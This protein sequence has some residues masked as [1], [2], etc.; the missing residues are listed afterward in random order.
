MSSTSPTAGT[1]DEFAGEVVRRS[2]GVPEAAAR[3]FAAAWT[4]RL[5][6]R[7]GDAGSPSTALAA[8]AAGALALVAGR[9]GGTP[10]VRAFTPDPERDGYEAAGSVLET[11][12]LDEPFLVDSVVAELTQRG[13]VVLRDVHPIIGTRRG[14]DGAL[15]EVLAPRTAPQRESVMHFELDR[16]LPAEQL[17]ALGDAVRRVLGIVD[18]V[19]ADVDLLRG[20]LAELEEVARAAAGHRDPTDAAET[21]A[22]LRWLASDRAVLL[23]AR[24]YALH[25]G[26]LEVVPG[27]GLGLLAD[28]D[29]STFA[30]GVPVS[31]LPAG[32]RE[33]VAGAQLLT[34]ARTNARSPVHRRDRMEDISV[35]RL[36]RDGEPVGISR[37]LA[38]LTTRA[39]AEPASTI[40]VLRRK[41][42]QILDAEDLVPGSH[43]HK[44]AVAAFDAFPKD[45]LLN[46]PADDLRRAIVALLGLRPGE[47]RVL[48][49]RAADDRSAS[50]IVAL[51]RAADRSTL[52]RRL[53]ALL[54]HRFGTGGIELTEVLTEDDRV[55]LHVSVHTSGT[56]PE[57]DVAELQEQ[58]RALA[59]TW[60]DLLG[61]LL[62]ERHGPELGRALAARWAPR[63]PDFYKAATS[64]RLGVE[65]VEVL[66]GMVTRGDSF[67]VGLADAR[68]ADGGPRTRV[69]LY[70]RGPKVELTQ[71]TA[72][73]EHLGLRVIE[74]VA[75]RLLADD[76][77]WVQGFIVLGDDDRPLDVGGCHARVA[78]CLAAAFRGRTE[79][80][81]LHR[82]VI[83]G[84]LDWRRIA[85]LRAY[86]RYRQRLGSRYTES[87]QNE[88]IT[89]HPVLTAKLLR[90]FE[91]RFDP[92]HDGD[93]TAEQDLREEI[94]ADLDAIELLDHDRILRNQLG[95]IDATVRT[96]IFREGRT[97][98]AFKLRSADVPAMPQPAPLW[99]IY[100]YSPTMEGIH[101]R[102]GPIARGGIRWSDRMD[103]RTEVFGLMRAQMTK[104]AVIVPTG[105]KGGFLLKGA[106][107]GGEALKDAVRREYVAYIGALLD[108]TDDRRDGRVVHPE[109]VR[110]RDEDDAYLVVAADKGTATFSDT[111][112][113]VSLRRGFWLGDAFASGGSTG[114]DHKALGITARGAWESVKRHFSELGID[115][116]A[117]PFTAVGIGD[118]SGDVFGNGMLL[119]RTIRLVAAYDHRH[120]FLDPDPDPAAGHA[121]RERLFAL[122]GRGQGSSWD[123]YD[124]ERI[125][126][127]G[128]VW[129]RTA[130][131]IPVSPEVRAALGIEDEALA[132]TDLI[133]AILRAPVDLLF[134][135]GIGTVVKASTESDADAQDR[136]SD[137]LRV[138]AADLR[139]R[140]VGEGGN[141]GF[142]H[143]ARIE[144]ARGGG[145]INADFIDNSAGV[146]CSDH[147]VNLKVLLDLAVAR[148]EL[149]PPARDAL[150]REVTEDVVGHVLYD[151][152][153]QAQIIAQE[154]RRSPGRMDALED[155]M[156][157]LE[158]R[159]ALDRAGEGLPGTDE[160]GDRRRVG[161]GLLRPE[162][163]VLVAYAKRH[164]ATALLDGPLP[165]EPFFAEDLERYFPPK[166]VASF[167]ALVPEH[168]LRRELVATIAANDLVNAL[169]PTFAS[170]GLGELGASPEAVV[171]A[172]RLA[173]AT[174]GAD[175]RWAAIEA[176]GRDVAVD[177]RWELMA[178]VD[179]LVADTARWH[180]VHDV[181]VDLAEAA[182][183]GRDGFERLGTVLPQLR[184]EAWRVA[185]DELAERLLRAGVPEDLA[186]AHT[187][188]GALVHA[189]DIVVV[190]A[191]SGRSVEEVAAVFF[192]VGERLRLEWLERAIDELPATTR[193]HRWAVQAVRDDVLGARAAL[194][195]RALREGDGDAAQVVDA[196][197][198]SRRDV[199]GRLTAFT[200]AL[201]HDG[202]AD[203]AGL[204]LAVRQLR[205]LAG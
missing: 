177:V 63:F 76:E 51:P 4:R 163:A 108:L 179:A 95:A 78:D 109:G 19:V 171:R 38:L 113:E 96:N 178:G 183:R 88:V 112:N 135:G 199:L 158:A 104:N 68:A 8:E 162:L 1:Q 39:R 121:E 17:D 132:P 129:P 149:E 169:G 47:V 97:V 146:D 136:A 191:E 180:L 150:L 141:L 36:G 75:T 188:Q 71:A 187:L 134:N 145:L 155:L 14:P 130:K 182:V 139:C 79:S 11:S 181:E 144:F 152:F 184:S 82:L 34:A 114:Y 28:D 50:I 10:A 131:S 151:S 60:D 194:A 189:P 148:G 205:V 196:F 100:V 110:V 102:G 5:R 123:D 175:A 159:G 140:V 61:D 25:D 27:S 46:A 59:R 90:L 12:T 35:L 185:H 98:I 21:A 31:E 173:R 126:A 77:L 195:R 116:E 7:D 106:P 170:Q 164:L 203:L 154:V 41:L 30:G 20:R 200:R 198:E 167:A 143:G 161:G 65:D 32:A 133:R 80:D 202:Q 160:M 73:L 13:L 26:V 83:T 67:A 66:D 92:A 204:G 107:S 174:T 168:P 118:M 23:G 137:A 176:L 99:E 6:A 54:V 56:L 9:T 84:G 166:V 125:S 186:R 15:L 105:A 190:A 86:R 192:E 33:R 157:L 111:A 49:R 117:D 69:A 2:P 89:A 85:V 197:L 156:E 64:P 103:Y 55:Q 93:E 122:G 42:T 24:E 165:D 37:I 45:E 128:G 16:R 58:V 74:E 70:R 81:A 40:P 87:F 22:F 127:G 43:D 124:R 172:V 62:A 115:P 138:D 193:L 94:L 3:A 153:Q 52:R 18:R 120:V 44:A 119:S 91:L 72:L 142:T 48:V 201:A 53:A 147:E 57:V 29:S 101:L